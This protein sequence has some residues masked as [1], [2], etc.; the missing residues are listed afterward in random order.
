M[1]AALPTADWGAADVSISVPMPDRRIVWLYG[2]TLTSTPGKFPHSTAIV[3]TAG[4]LHVSRHGAQLLPNDDALHFYWITAAAS[5]DNGHVKVT[6]QRIEVTGAG[7]WAFRVTGTRTA[8]VTIDTIGDL[9]F[10]H[11]T[12][13]GDVPVQN[14]VRKDGGPYAPW[15]STVSLVATGQVVITGLPHTLQHFSYGPSA[16]PEIR[17]ASGRTLVTVCQNATPPTF[18]TYRPLFF[19]VTR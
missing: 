6:A 1:F 19:E 16:H 17:L 18:D 5:I 8:V 15:T 13:E 7:V 12:T 9:A 14:I 10:D 2:D 3:Q 4:C 11:W